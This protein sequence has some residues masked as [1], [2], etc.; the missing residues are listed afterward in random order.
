MC[1]GVKHRLCAWLQT[2]IL[3][4]ISLREQVWDA[5]PFQRRE[6]QHS[7]LKMPWEL[8]TSSVPLGGRE[9]EHLPF[10]FTCYFALRGNSDK[11]TAALLSVAGGSFRPHARPEQVRFYKAQVPGLERLLRSAH[12]AA[13]GRGGARCWLSSSAWGGEPALSGCL[14][15]PA[16]LHQL[17][18]EAEKSSN[19]CF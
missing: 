1:P 7:Y 19:K 10:P 18:Q 13:E 6:T 4:L 2:L 15:Q 17:L 11:P 16:V 14:K 8:L 3:L 12:K 5:A 9:S